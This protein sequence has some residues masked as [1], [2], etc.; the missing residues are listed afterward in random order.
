MKL[1]DFVKI[2]F[3]TS[4]DYETL[5]KYERGKNRFMLMRFISIQY[6]ETANLLNING[7]NPTYV[8]DCFRMIT[9]R[10]NRTPNW[11]W[12]KVSKQ[13][14]KSKEFEPEDYTIK[15][16]LKQNE[17]TMR[18]YKEILKSPRKNEMLLE[19]EDLEKM[20]KDNGYEK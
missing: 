8:N 5:S 19:L 3:S 12:T 9:K 20:L 7:T 2:M 15:F 10:F 11:V 17:S 14:K 6:P 1:F 18:D 13:K 16:Y 4:K